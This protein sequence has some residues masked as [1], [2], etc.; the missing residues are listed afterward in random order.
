MSAFQCPQPSSSQGVVAAGE[1]ACEAFAIKLS[2]PRK[3]IRAAE[4]SSRFRANTPPPRRRD[5]SFIPPPIH[6]HVQSDGNE[7][8]LHSAL[9]RN[10][11]SRVRQ[12]LEEDGTLGTMPLFDHDFEPPLC[13]AARL[14]CSSEITTLLEA[15]GAKWSDTDKRG[16]SATEL[17]EKRTR[18]PTMYM[19]TEPLGM[20]MDV[21]AFD[22]MIMNLIQRSVA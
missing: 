11:A 6:H 9:Y 8:H 17:A 2:P 18:P 22:N 21:S 4:H 13:C 19:V 14:G 1:E 20:Y 12:L 3:R 10:D 7:S 5:E 16:C 15:H